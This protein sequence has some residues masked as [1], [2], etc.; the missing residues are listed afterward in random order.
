MRI[1][2]DKVRS[3]VCRLDNDRLRNMLD[4]SAGVVNLSRDGRSASRV[5]PAP[6]RYR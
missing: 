6:C 4:R 1:D 2:R 5:C 3:A